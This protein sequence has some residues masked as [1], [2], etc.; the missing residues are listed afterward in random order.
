MI[1]A[2]S[3]AIGTIHSEVPATGPERGFRAGFFVGGRAA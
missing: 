3:Y 1:R 2:I